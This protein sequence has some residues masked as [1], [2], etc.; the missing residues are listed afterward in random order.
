MARQKKKKQIEEAEIPMSS[1]IDV[2]FL[3]L[4][5]FIVTQKPVIEETLLGVNLPSANQPSS[6]DSEPSQLFTVDV[7]KM[8]ENS[9][10]FYGVNGMPTPLAAMKDQLLML[11]E[12]DPD[13]TVIIKCG[14]NAKHSKLVTLL[15][16]CAEAGLS[17][18][19]LVELP[20]AY[21]GQ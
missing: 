3:L 11:A 18:L 4:I 1:M 14:P 10:K 16:A 6:S 7:V 15:D 17:K 21:Q 2:V 8:G 12:N 9:A 19:N 5:Y 20:L 13:T